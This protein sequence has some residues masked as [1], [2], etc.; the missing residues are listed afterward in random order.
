MPP[1][2]GATLMAVRDEL[3]TKAQ[4]FP[5]AWPM[6][7]KRTPPKARLRASFRRSVTRPGTATRDNQP[8]A[9]VTSTR[10]LTIA[11]AIDRL[12]AEL[13]RLGA[14]HEILSSNVPVSIKGLPFSVP[15]EPPDTGV[16]VYF[17]LAKKPLCFACDKWDRVADNIAAIAQHIDALRR[18]DR[19]GVGKVEQA[20]AGY[21]AL[22]PAADDWRVILGVGDYATLDQVDAAFLEKA[23]TLHPDAGGTHDEMARLTAARDFA[24][25]VLA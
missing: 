12:A 16:A 15:T 22:P 17:D 24:R 4:R 18:I 21:L 7:W 1:V 3:T 5:L 6:D 19:Y 2:R 10:A 13:G 20:F 23:R 11:D 8:P 14:H 25:K 9:T